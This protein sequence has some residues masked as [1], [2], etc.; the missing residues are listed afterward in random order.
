MSELPAGL[1]FDIYERLTL[2]E[3]MAGIGELED[4]ELLPRIALHRKD[5]NAVLQGDLLLTGTYIGEGEKGAKSELEHRIPVEITLPLK[6]IQS[7]DN[8]GV[9][10][11]NFDVEILSARNLN[12]TGIISLKGIDTS[13][14]QSWT[15]EGEAEFVHEPGSKQS[16]ESELNNRS[17]KKK[18][19]KKIVEQ[20]E[21]L[22]MEEDQIVEEVVETET[23]QSE[24]MVAETVEQTEEII[25]EQPQA[26]LVKEIVEEPVM[27]EMVV[28]E[29][30]AE[31]P[32]EAE[33][34]MLGRTQELESKEMKIAFNSI[35][36]E[37]TE[38]G[39]A[40]SSMNTLLNQADG[41]QAVIHE[42]EVEQKT[43]ITSGN[44]E[45]TTAEQG[46]KW[47]NLLLSA[48]HEEARFSK[49][50][51]CI[52]QREETLE[53]IAARYDKNPKEIVLHNR[54][55]NDHVREGQII[56]IP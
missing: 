48:E 40:A 23:P 46:V 10:I 14:E 28:P 9:E 34:P 18:G 36:S 37:S 49:V 42:T 39:G 50:R 41:E 32:C 11:E 8:I 47:R 31:V 12:I 19:H 3:D 52:V 29:P 5:E 20:Q 24:E 25:V 2:S 1:R 30:E 38:W 13:T 44:E 45:Q 56:Y 55:E 4:V 35:K 33:D 17:E 51:M 26:E 27:E 22:E 15:D 7:M 16:T 6:R 43:E 21:M 54:M 53:L